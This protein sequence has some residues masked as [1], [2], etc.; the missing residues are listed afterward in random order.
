MEHGLAS[1][2]ARSLLQMSDYDFLIPVKLLEYGN[3]KDMPA[4]R[5]VLK[6]PASVLI[7]G[8]LPSLCYLYYACYRSV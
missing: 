5:P 7:L 4:F 6:A 1:G 8:F 3:L 2:M